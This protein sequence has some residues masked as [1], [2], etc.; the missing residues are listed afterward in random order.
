MKAAY[1]TAL[2]KKPDTNNISKSLGFFNVFGATIW[3]MGMICTVVGIVGML[4]NLDDKNQIG[5]ITALAMLSIH[6]S[7]ILYL[8]VV[9]PFTLLL[10]KKQKVPTEDDRRVS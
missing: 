6:Y 2:E 9:L 8:V 1:M 5:P 7:A 3:I 10:K 4:Q